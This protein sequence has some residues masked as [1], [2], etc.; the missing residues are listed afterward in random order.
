MRLMKCMS[1]WNKK[2]SGVWSSL[3]DGKGEMKYYSDGR[4]DTEYKI[5]TTYPNGQ[6]IISG[7]GEMKCFDGRSYTKYTLTTTYPDGKKR[8][9]TKIRY[10][11]DPENNKEDKIYYN[12][13]LENEE[14]INAWKKEEI[15]KIIRESEE[16]SSDPGLN[17][18]IPIEED[19]NKEQNQVVMSIKEKT[20]I[21]AKKSY[22]NTVFQ[23]PST[24]VNSFVDCV[25]ESIVS[26]AKYVIECNKYGYR[27]ELRDN[28]YY[29]IG[30]TK[31]DEGMTLKK[32]KENT[33][34]VKV[35]YFK[36]IA[37][38]YNF[39][40]DKSLSD[41]EFVEIVEKK[42]Y[43]SKSLMEKL[44]SQMNNNPLLQ[45]ILL[46]LINY[47]L[48]D[49]AGSIFDIATSCGSNR[50]CM[51]LYGTYRNSDG[52]G[53]CVSNCTPNEYNFIIAPLTRFLLYWV[54]NKDRINPGTYINYQNIH[55]LSNIINI[56]LLSY[57]WKINGSYTLLAKVALAK[58]SLV[59]TRYFLKDYD[60]IKKLDTYFKIMSEIPTGFLIEHR[61]TDGVYSKLSKEF[62]ALNKFVV[63]Y[64]L[65]DKIKVDL[66]IYPKSKRFYSKKHEDKTSKTN[67]LRKIS[68]VVEGSSLITVGITSFGITG[69]LLSVIAGYGLCATPAGMASLVLINV[70]S[71]GIF[72]ENFNGN[73]SKNI[74]T[75]EL[76]KEKFYIDDLGITETQTDIKKFTFCRHCSN[77]WLTLK[78]E[79]RN[80]YLVEI[81]SK[82][83][84][85]NKN[86]TG[87]FESISYQMRLN[88]DNY[89]PK[90]IRWESCKYIEENF[91]IDNKEK[92]IKEME[93]LTTEPDN[94]IIKAVSMRYGVNIIIIN[95]FS[96]EREDFNTTILLVNCNGKYY[97]SDIKI[98]NSSDVRLDKMKNNFNKSKNK[99]N[100]KFKEIHMLF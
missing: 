85:I 5:I 60:W 81:Y 41:K 97:P 95:D 26:D 40:V 89:K 90:D 62:K 30:I 36:Q 86:V 76:C 69:N 52:I 77:K 100:E 19:E 25:T 15:M 70:S 55:I 79:I 2:E 87:F 43:D 35:K 65:L 12:D 7:K 54:G 82:E 45:K 49:F 71:I 47:F 57:D 1:Q 21:L 75:C 13:D 96:I 20:G 78:N 56:G 80:Y 42:Y 66:L 61:F 67:A 51:G 22:Y 63:D 68:G 93:K 84:K 3:K 98:K 27:V 11:N 94:K 28:L 31:D 33:Y 83:Y 46:P 39:D 50:N 92:Y 91:N 58:S 4:S 8:I 24:L 88:G 16:I 99:L 34:L 44:I 17:P 10:H 72:G 48:H 29:I 53:Y 23:I 14:C 74:F 64:E 73:W 32:F 9:S 59:I 6:R 38:Y 18:F 37:E